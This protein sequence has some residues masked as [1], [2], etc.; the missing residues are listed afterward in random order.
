MISEAA[1]RRRTESFQGDG[2]INTGR[3]PNQSTSTG[4]PIATR[5]LLDNLSRG[6]G[7]LATRPALVR[8]GQLAAARSLA[9]YLVGGTVRELALGRGA[10]DLDLA[11]SAQTL[12]LARDL[13]EALGGTYVLLDEAERTARVVWQDEIL[14][15][16]EFRAPTLEGDLRG[17][18][19][20]LNALAVGLN[21][22]LGQSPPELIDPGGGLEDLAG[23]WLRMVAPE[24]FLHDPLRLLRAYR[25]AATHGFQVTPETTAAIR[26]AAPAF[27]RVAGERV[28]QELFLLLGAPAAAPVLGEM[29]AVG[30]LSRVFPE[31][32]DMKGV[33]QNG[34]HHLDVYG[35]SLATLASLEEV[36][37]A[38]ERFFG[39]LAGEVVRYAQTPPK[40]V[41]LKLAALFHDVGKPRVQARR[42]QPERYTFYFHEKVGLEIFSRVAS[43]LRC[44]QAET[45]TVTS[46][47]QMHMRPFLLLPAF[48]ERELSF[49]ALGRLVRAAR[50]ELAGLFVLA[51]ADSLA[52]QGPLK[53]ADSE[54]V[55]A[56]LAEAAYQFLTERLEPQEQHPRL[57]SGHD[58]IRLGLTPG[59]QFRRLLTAVE[60]AQW[61]G[62]VK[63]REEALEMVRRLL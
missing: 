56:D 7:A 52:G 9:V 26:Q 59:P 53:P 63:T 2:H 13:A 58:L 32:E 1:R 36:L 61:E 55:L 30:L 23:G 21:A 22:V 35:H 37:A 62:L 51:M 28:H 41:L 45:R 14:D 16:A 17:R 40:A 18:D 10:K 29:E 50:P 3:L 42:S 44:S 31:L 5:I 27:S 46:L 24:N 33:E 57:V 38:P 60:E 15:L 39:D 34:Y 25:F 54:A 48:R 11:V 12:D 49:R 19:F 43:R 6:L 47:I 4:V 8:L 20:T